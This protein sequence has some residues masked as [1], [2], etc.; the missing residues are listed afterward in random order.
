[1]NDDSLPD[2]PA[3][4]FYTAQEILDLALEWGANATLIDDGGEV[5]IEL[6]RADRSI[7]LDLGQPAQFYG[8]FWCRAWVSVPA[9]P[10]R[11]CDRWN[12]FP[13]FGAFS[14]VYDVNDFPE[15][16]EAGFL[17][18]AVQVIEFD[19]YRKQQ[20]IFLDVMLFWY[21]IELVQS[22]VTSGESDV[23]QL[24]ANF[25]KNGLSQWWF[26]EE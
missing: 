7:H 20:D 18:R 26:G 4:D 1:M 25:A 8:D 9:A 6:E 16:S 13:Y 2:T 23:E 15:H 22:G 11:F 10:H 12:E 17:I 19:R 24:R 5:I 14:V 3:R 21:A